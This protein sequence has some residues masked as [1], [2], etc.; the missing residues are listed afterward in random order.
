MKTDMWPRNSR[1]L[2]CNGRANASRSREVI[3]PSCST[4]VRP[5]LKYC[6]H[7]WGSP[8]QERQGYAEASPEEA[9]EKIRGL[10]NLSYQTR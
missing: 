3:L 9:I 8:A 1:I 7:V 10:E 6:N 2:G 4:I 5:D